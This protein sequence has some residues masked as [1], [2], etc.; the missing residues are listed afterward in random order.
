MLNEFEDYLK[1]VKMEGRRYAILLCQENS[2]SLVHMV[3]GEI[4]DEH[5]IIRIQSYIG[6]TSERFGE[7]NLEN[8]S[9]LDKRLYETAVDLGEKKAS[10]WGMSFV[11]LTKSN[12]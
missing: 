7:I 10:N 9:E 5:F 3:R 12:V 4:K 8:F 2:K 6:N 11:D 1:L